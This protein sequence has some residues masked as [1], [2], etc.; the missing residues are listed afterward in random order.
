MTKDGRREGGF[1][2][3]EIIIS[4]ALFALISMAGIA[5]IDAVIRVEEGTAG[6]LDRIGQLQRA[7]FLMTR[8]LEQIAGGTL[9]EVDEGVSF[10]RQS[11]SVLEGNVPA[12]YVL[13]GDTLIRGIGDPAAPGQTIIGGVTEAEWSFFFPGRGWRSELPVD[14][15]GRA[16]QPSAVAVDIILDESGTPSGSLRRVV[17]LP[18]PPAP[19]LPPL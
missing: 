15:A 3:I 8:D 4:L 1:T 17:E 7:M 18:T 10:E 5:L 6:R 13:R 9:R 12:R 11:A 2:L 16:E 14:E 19:G